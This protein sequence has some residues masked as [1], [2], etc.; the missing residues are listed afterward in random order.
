M[1][2]IN[3]FLVKQKN[4]KKYSQYKDNSYDYMISMICATSVR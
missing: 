2:V 3:V 1:L 4:K